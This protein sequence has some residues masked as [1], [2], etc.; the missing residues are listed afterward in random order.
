MALSRTPL[1]EGKRGMPK[2]VLPHAPRF[3]QKRPARVGR[4]LHKI[5]KGCER[6]KSGVYEIP[7]AEIGVVEVGEEVGG[8]D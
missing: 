2:G 8:V 1:Q 3:D 4:R 7:R 6:W 5:S